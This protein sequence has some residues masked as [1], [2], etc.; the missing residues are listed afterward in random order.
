MTVG[1]EFKNQNLK[2]VKY[3]IIACQIHKLD[4]QD[5]QFE[6]SQGYSKGQ[7]E[8]TPLS[9]ILP[10][11]FTPKEIHSRASTE[12]NWNICEVFLCSS[13]FS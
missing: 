10:L 11:Y 1:R 6:I 12:T 9:H 8:Y 5:C 2:G 4:S 7:E 13:S 3:N